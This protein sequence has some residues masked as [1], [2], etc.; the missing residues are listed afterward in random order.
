MVPPELWEQLEPVY[1]HVLDTGGAVRDVPV[2]EPPGADGRVRERL[3]S[4]YPVRIG[5]EIIGVG[6]VVP[7][8][9]RPGAAPRGSARP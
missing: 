8:R 4:H 9:H 1:R 3:A 7:R 2:I 6:V 5:D